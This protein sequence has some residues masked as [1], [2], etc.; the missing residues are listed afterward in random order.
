MSKF[1]HP[2]NTE[3]TDV[4]WSIVPH[5]D[6]SKR[7][8]VVYSKSKDTEDGWE[9]RC[10]IEEVRGIIGRIQALRNKRFVI[11]NG[12]YLQRMRAVKMRVTPEDIG[13]VLE[14]PTH[15]DYKAAKSNICCNF[16]NCLCSLDILKNLTRRKSKKRTKPGPDKRA[17]L[18]AEKKQ[19]KTTVDLSEET[20][21]LSEGTS[22]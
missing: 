6:D 8:V 4:Y 9:V 12:Y 21:H 7:L 17:K 14:N 1:K 13:K 19:R 2:E 11:I 10:D 5:T 15:Y 18:A 22:F 20:E 3:Y 16:V